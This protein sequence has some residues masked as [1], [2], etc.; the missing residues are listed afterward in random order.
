MVQQNRSQCRSTES[1]IEMDICRWPDHHLRPASRV[2]GRSETGN[3]GQER[4]KLSSRLVVSWFHR[5]V[6]LRS[7]R[8]SFANFAVIDFD[9]RSRLKRTKFST[10]KFAK[11]FRK[12][13]K[14]F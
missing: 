2:S 14:G 13:R 11:G 8:N 5:C 1:A 12:E 6:P 4:V 9:L 10:A 7:L 3:R